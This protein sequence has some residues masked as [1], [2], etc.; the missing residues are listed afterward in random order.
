LLIGL[1]LSVGV[2]MLGALIAL[3]QRDEVYQE[4]VARP[5]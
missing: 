5:G 1:A 3:A 2:L 4:P